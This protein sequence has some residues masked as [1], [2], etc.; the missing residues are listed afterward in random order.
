M[1]GHIKLLI[2]YSTSVAIIEI[3]SIIFDRH[4]DLRFKQKYH[5][6]FQVGWYKVYRN[7]GKIL[8]DYMKK[9]HKYQQLSR[10]FVKRF[11]EKISGLESIIKYIKKNV[12][13]TYN[14]KTVLALVSHNN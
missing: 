14:Q 13:P 5:L 7:I 8:C 2:Y 6:R 9:I 11:V 12:V 4:H 1:G 3:N 10:F